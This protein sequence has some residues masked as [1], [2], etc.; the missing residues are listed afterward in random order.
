MRGKVDPDLVIAAFADAQYGVVS[1]VQLIK[2][3]LSADA[4]DRRVKARRLRRLHQG[5]YAVGHR[6]LIVEGRWMAA[7]LASGSDAV[8]SHKSAATAWD[9]GRWVGG[10]I[11]VSVPT[12]AGRKKRDGIRLHRSATLTARD[13]AEVRGVPVTSV[14]RTII[15]L[16]RTI[17]GR[18]L[19][20]VI[21]LADQSRRVDFD[22]LRAANSASLQ[23][24]LRTYDPAPTD[25]ELEE[26]FLQLCDDHDIPRPE[27]RAQIEGY[28]VDFLW[29]GE[30]LVVEVDGYRYHRAPSRFEADR[31]RDVVLI[32]NG[33][34]VLRFTWRQIA[35][36][37]AWV[38]AAVTRELGISS[39]PWP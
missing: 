31:E 25:S 37:A 30:R 16:S 33:W 8:L 28:R 35:H 15:D 12:R 36:R 22:D 21:D 13:V 20:H 5:V 1:R 27:T 34:R 10:A 26:A 24:V 19:E 6:R 17:K 18:R 39:R 4:V 23:A 7:V 2:A 38:A 11:E 29:R 14:E 3:G 9:L 32:A